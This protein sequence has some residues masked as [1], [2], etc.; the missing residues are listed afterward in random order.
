MVSHTYRCC[1]ALSPSPNALSGR[2]KSFFSRQERRA[3]LAELPPKEKKP[4]VRTLITREMRIVSVEE[5][6]AARSGGRE[7]RA[8][9]GAKFRCAELEGGPVFWDCGY[10]GEK[11]LKRHETRPQR[12]R[13]CVE[14]KGK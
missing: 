9:M 11:N 14:C 1:A 5:L 6:V 4:P 8:C 2:D 3:L 7:Y 12:T 13:E 10:Y